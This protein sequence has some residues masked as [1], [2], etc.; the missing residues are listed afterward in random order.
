MLGDNFPQNEQTINA[1]AIRLLKQE[2]FDQDVEWKLY[3][4][5]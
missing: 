1:L 3:G 4:K 5:C 2:S